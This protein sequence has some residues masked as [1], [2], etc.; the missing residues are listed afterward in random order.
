[1]KRIISVTPLLCM[2]VIL[3]FIT[4]AFYYSGIFSRSTEETEAVP[5][6]T[7]SGEEYVNVN[8][9]G[10]TPGDPQD[11]SAAIQTAINYAGESQIG[12][13]KILGNTDYYLEEG[14]VIKKGVRL[15]LGQNTRLFVLEDFRAV[16][17][18]K[19]ASIHNGMIEVV[20]PG[21]QSEVIYLDGD[22]K[23]WSWD[24]TQIKNIRIINS[25]ESFRGT[26]VSL[27]A[28]G[29]DHFISFVNFTNLNL[30][31]FEYGIHLEAV[32][33]STKEDYTYI[34]GNRF[35]NITIDSCVHCIHIE[36]A[37]TIPNEVSGNIFSNLQVQIS[38]ETERVMTVR[39]TSNRFDGVIWDEHLL[40][41]SRPVLVFTQQS[42][43]SRLDT[44][45]AVTHIRDRGQSNML[46]HPAQGQ[47]P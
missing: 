29:P 18:R 17:I 36:G 1:M 12:T 40:T 43:K 16:D 10:A 41:H 32:E 33:Q 6:E 8:D 27:A 26:A 28:D 4:T 30:V 25:S 19:N 37:V 22:Q 38:A 34:N 35:T 39:G 47:E 45:L 24:S 15:E 20:D 9:F 7:I 21:F 13:V 23:F 31:G 44:N 2:A 46:L 14:I 5:A 11:D 42:S 3:F